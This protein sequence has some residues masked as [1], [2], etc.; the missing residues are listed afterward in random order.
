[1]Q[2]FKQRLNDLVNSKFL[3]EYLQD[4]F[5]EQLDLVSFIHSDLRG[6]H[7]TADEDEV[8]PG[9]IQVA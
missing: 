4:L 8:Y 2:L 9:I 1:M 6:D 3:K 5:S 7:Q